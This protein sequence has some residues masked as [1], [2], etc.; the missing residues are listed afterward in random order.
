[1]FFSLFLYLSN[2]TTITHSL[3]VKTYLRKIKSFQ[4]KGNSILSNLIN[5]KINFKWNLFH[6]KAY[7]GI[8]IEPNVKVHWNQY[9][10]NKPYVLHHNRKRCNV[11]MLSTSYIYIRKGFQYSILCFQYSSVFS[12]FKSLNIR[13]SRRHKNNGIWSKRSC[14]RKILLCYTMY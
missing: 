12:I 13:P 10:I 2:N 1:M 11:S 3:S 8:L 5:I 7:I 14:V 6:A 4:C 9:N